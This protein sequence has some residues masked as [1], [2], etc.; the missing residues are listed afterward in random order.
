MNR[1]VS[2]RIVFTA[3]HDHFVERLLVLK[4]LIDRVFN[5]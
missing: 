4:L 5:K 2:R 1:N 3:I